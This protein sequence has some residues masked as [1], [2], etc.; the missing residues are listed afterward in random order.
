M[1]HVGSKVL[2]HLHKLAPHYFTVMPKVSGTF[3]YN[4]LSLMKVDI[5]FHPNPSV[6]G[7]ITKR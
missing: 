4:L 7:I 6:F 3:I 1:K 5:Y 2:F